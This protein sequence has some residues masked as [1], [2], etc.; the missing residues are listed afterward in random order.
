PGLPDAPVYPHEPPY[1]CASRADKLARLRQAMRSHG[2]DVHLV[3]TLDDIAWLLNLRGADVPYN[4]V[5]LAHALVGPDHATLFVG[6]GKISAAL[7]A[8]LAADG[9][10]VAPY[11]LA[12]EALGSLQRDQVLLIDPARVTCGVF[13]ALYPVVPR[14]YA[15]TPTT[16]IN[17]NNA[18]VELHLA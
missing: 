17:L 18:E 16:P 10:D 1:A 8:S 6:D 12:A 13:H 3:S 11:G 9:I 7:R 5:F 4:P 14:I 15:I 2:A